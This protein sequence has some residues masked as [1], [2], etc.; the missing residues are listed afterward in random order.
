[1]QEILSQA[2]CFLQ[3]KLFPIAEEELGSLSDKHRRLISAISFSEC[4]KFIRTFEGCPGRPSSDRVS[5]AHAFIAK[6]IFNISQ[7]K[8]LLVWIKTDP[9]LRAICGWETKSSVPSEATFS[10]AFAQFA[11]TDV[12]A[13]IHEAFIKKYHAER[14]AL[15]VSRDSTEIVAR[16]KAAKKPEIR[17]VRKIQKK[18]G[19]P[20]KGA[21]KEPIPQSR[22]QK[23]LNMTTSEMLSDLPKECDIGCKK[24]SKGYKHSWRGYKLHIDTAD[25]DIP[26]SAVLTSASVHDSQVAL[27]LHNITKNRITHL[28]EVMDSAYDAQ[29]IRDALSEAGH[30]ALIDFNHRSPNDTRAF[31]PCEAQRYKVRSSAERVNSYLKDN[32]SG[33]M[34]RVKGH[35]KVF[36]HLMFSLLAIT[37]DRSLKAHL[38]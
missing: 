2:W 22:L 15:H 37:I 23:Q 33:I 19:R 10:R 5:I 31:D 6:A 27:P 32:F 14:I 20:I 25:G 18:K 12:S 36:T 11:K 28:Y 16:E 17:K 1:M 3:A 13:K 26:I 9:V 34:I 35:A 21:I 38:T 4:R 24:D 8:T 30:V 29:V 7:T